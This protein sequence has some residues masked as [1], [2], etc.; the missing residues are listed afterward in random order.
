MHLLNLDM[1]TY[2]PEIQSGVY[3]GVFCRFSRSLRFTL[4]SKTLFRAARVNARLP[5]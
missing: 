1:H 2:S 4:S 5:R 3:G